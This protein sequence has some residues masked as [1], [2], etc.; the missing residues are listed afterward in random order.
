M[1]AWSTGE[2]AALSAAAMANRAVP[3]GRVRGS[4]ATF[5]LPCFMLYIIRSLEGSPEFALTASGA[6]GRQRGAAGTR[7]ASRSR[8]LVRDRACIVVDFY[9][10]ETRRLDRHHLPADQADP[11]CPADGA[12]PRAGRKASGAA[13]DLRRVN[14][15]HCAT[16]G[17]C[18]RLA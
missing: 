13:L 1:L 6:T 5:E 16:S 9:S 15:I 17:R 3:Q 14:I 18:R 11:R 10:R 7:P 4:T 8:R 2:A 12:V